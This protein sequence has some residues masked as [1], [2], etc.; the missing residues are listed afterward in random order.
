MTTI[1]EACEVNPPK[2]KRGTVAD[3]LPVTFVPMPAVD[4]DSGTIKAPLI[5]PYAEVA[6]GFTAF[7]DEDV[8][9]AK[10]TPCMENGKAAIARALTNGLGFGSTEF[11]VLRSRAGVLPEFVYH[12]IRKESF[13]S[14]AEMQMTGSV[15]QKR[16]PAEFIENAEIPL[17]PLPEQ[18][19]IV[20]AIEQLTARVDA[21][22]ARLAKVPAILKRFRQAVL[23]AACSGRLT[24]DWRAVNACEPVASQLPALLKSRRS[25]YPAECA[26]AKAERRKRPPEPTDPTV[27]DQHTDDLPPIP[28]SWAWLYLPGL[29]ELNRGRSRNRPRDAAHL[30]G[31]PYPFIQTGDIARSGGRITAHRQTYSEAGLAQSRLWP[32]DTLAITIAANI[33]DSSILTYPACFP[34]SVVGLVADPAACSPAYV[35]AFV[36]TARDRLDQF[37]PETTQKNINLEIL[38]ALAVPVP[39]LPEQAEIVRRVEALMNLADTIERRVALAQA[40]SGKLTQSILARAFRAELVPTEAA[41]ARAESRPYEPAAALLERARAARTSVF[42]PG[43]KRS[44]HDREAVGT[45]TP[46]L[47]LTTWRIP[48][49]ADV[50]ASIVH[51]LADDPHLA[52]AKLYKLTYLGAAIV[53]A[54]LQPPPLREAAGPYNTQTQQAVEAKAA[55]ARLFTTRKRSSTR[56]TNTYATDSRTHEAVARAK[57]AFGSRWGDFQRLLK[58]AAPWNFTDI[59]LHATT[60][61]AWNDL[62]ARGSAADENSVVVAVHA[63]SDRKGRFGNTSIKNAMKT[64]AQLG[65]KPSGSGP[66]LSDSHQPGLFYPQPGNDFAQ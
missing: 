50:E 19:R 10:I 27:P 37:A 26:K 39:P 47:R 45:E 9:M 7:R 48:E 31:G 14:A 32:A 16:V 36:R 28:E 34:D 18:K 57:A 8:I 22:R 33:A 25:R 13:R 40:R 43:G 59:E 58:T 5:R 65:L 11:H 64:L 51:A 62:L 54:A 42:A 60:H 38:N 24:E 44:K 12:F 30:Y 63:W 20:E 21:A 4:A 61:A 49:A 15:G 23:A 56:P 6:K 66:L 55:S 1:G 29:G 35:E 3:D 53:N 46:A 41:R 17:P 2:P 52:Q